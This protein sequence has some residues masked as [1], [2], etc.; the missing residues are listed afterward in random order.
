[1]RRRHASATERGTLLA[2]LVLCAECGA[3]PP[4]LVL[5]GGARQMDQHLEP[6][7]QR[8]RRAF[9][10][11][12]GRTAA[13]AAGSDGDGAPTAASE[14]DAA[15]GGGLA[16]GGRNSIRVAARGHDGAVENVGE[17]GTGGRTAA[18]TDGW[19]NCGY[20]GAV[21]YVGE[22]GDRPLAEGEVRTYEYLD[23]TSVCVC[24][25]VCV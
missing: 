13:A 9:G 21:Q 5:R 7:P 1:M 22:G 11:T 25:C 24:V 10:R 16:V 19:A 20:D 12:G 3:T 6:L 2:V 17:G 14:E 15:A 8:P 4:A 18:A 23:H